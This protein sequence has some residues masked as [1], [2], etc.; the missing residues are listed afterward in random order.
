[1]RCNPITKTFLLAFFLISHI[2]ATLAAEPARELRGFLVFSAS[3]VSNYM[4]EAKGGLRLKGNASSGRIDEFVTAGGHI[5]RMDMLLGTVSELGADLKPIHEGAVKSKTGVPYWLGIWDKGLLVLNDNTV[6]YLDAAL[7]EVARITLEPRRYDQVTPVLTPTDFDTWEHRGYL[8]VNTGEL[9]VVPL[10]KP[11][12]ATPLTAVFR[13]ENGF[14]P[15]KQW[16]DPAD[17]TLNLLANTQKEERDAKLKPG[18]WRVIKGQVVLTYDLKD[19]HAP[20]LRT[21][22]HEKREIHDP[23]HLD[24]H[25]NGRQD[26]KVIDR[27]APYR[28][29]GPSKGAYIG[30]ISRT[31]PA[32]AEVF[33]ERGN[34]TLRHRAISRLKSRGRYEVKSLLQETRG[35][36]LW[37][38]AEGGRRYIESDL[39]ER[40]LRLLP[41]PYGELETLPDLRGVY[42]KV[43]AY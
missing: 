10:E 19:L 30:I 25:D 11:R 37:F 5:Y 7:K 33:E 3:G 42:F 41:E 16:I 12:S 14:S 27:R 34:G 22:V 32:Y 35:S 23:I 28:S 29:E 21:V 13:T 8:L 17:R 4:Q 24:S 20:A 40:V 18:E 6:I 26:G 36:A 38:P 2:G 15:D 31:T 43:L 1:M 9:F 39:E